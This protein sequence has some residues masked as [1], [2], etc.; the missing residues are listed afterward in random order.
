MKHP[1]FE[2]MG[3][4]YPAHLEAAFDRILCRIDELWETPLIHDYFSDLLIDKRGGRRGFPAE[5]VQDIV[6]LREY[7]D[8]MTFRAAERKEDAVRQLEMRGIALNAAAFLAAFRA[9]NQEL[10]DLFARAQLNLPLADGDDPLITA[11]LKRGH[12]V[13]AKIV[14]EA[15]ADV[16]LRNRIGL[17][18]LLVACGKTTLG[19]R[20]IAE[21]LI[22]KGAD[23]N[24]RDPLGNTP[25]LLAI[26]GGMFDL[27]KLLIRSGANITMSSPRHGSP[28]DA[29]LRA[30]SP[31]AA[32]VVE[33]LGGPQ[34]ERA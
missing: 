16:N 15:G 24:V 17:T 19:Y 20:V 1:K 10:V 3:R 30:T 31:D 33:L 28:L 8:I 34:A 2:G 5:V 13:V 26:S 4:E 12:T 18:P 22:A 21:A 14:L 27:A 32:E 23:M 11:A 25:L 6:R 7:H 9:G 29:A